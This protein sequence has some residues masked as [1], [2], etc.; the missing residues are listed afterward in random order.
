MRLAPG[1]TRVSDL[2]ERNA[3]LDRWLIALFL[4]AIAAPSADD[5][6]R[7]HG[8]RGPDAHE[9]RRGGARPVY[10]GLRRDL[11]FYPMLYDAYFADSF[12]LRDVLLRWHSLEKL[13]LFGVSPTPLVVMGKDDWMMYAR[14]D[15]LEI[16]RGAKPLAEQELEEWRRALESRRDYLARRGIEYLFVVGPNKETIYP[17][18]EPERYNRVGPTRMEQVVAYLSTHSDFRILDLRPALIEARREDTPDEHLYFEFGT[19][20]NGRGNLVAAREVR[21][22]LHELFP[23]VRELDLADLTKA[24]F[25][26][27]GDSAARRMYVEDLFPQRHTWFHL[28]SRPPPRVVDAGWD[29]EHPHRLETD[30]PA[31]PRAIVFHDSFGHGI[32]PLLGECFSRSTWMHVNDLDTAAIE[33]EAP[34]VVLQVVVERTFA[35]PPERIPDEL[36]HAPVSAVKPPSGPIDVR[37]RLD[38]LDGVHQLEGVGG[39]RIERDHGPE[40]DSVAVVTEQG[41]DLVSLPEFQWPATGRTFVDLD[42]TSPAS[43]NLTVFYLRRGKTEYDRRDAES[44]HLSAGRNRVALVILPDGIQGRLRFRPGSQVGRFLVHGLQVSS[45]APR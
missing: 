12:G 35:Y 19:H 14:E 20:W 1:F 34:D 39:T 25:D 27:G 8:A 5:W 38:P 29:A 45:A 11:L 10:H 6:M 42:I 18:Y 30:D 24:D 36:V 44:V 7:P 3:K 22:R 33:A 17:E 37:Y 21:K 16:F 13:F 4:A 26:D 2:V 41:S 32:E 9:L 28:A 43:T 15:S 23:R 31:L 40:G